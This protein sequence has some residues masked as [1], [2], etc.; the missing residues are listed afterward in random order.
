MFPVLKFVFSRKGAMVAC[1]NASA[2]V[3]QGEDWQSVT[4]ASSLSL[5]DRQRRISFG[6]AS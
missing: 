2:P 3:G 1:T 5:A 4:I 6:S